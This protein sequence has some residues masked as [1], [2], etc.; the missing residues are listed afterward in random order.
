M[1]EVEGNPSRSEIECYRAFETE[2]AFSNGVLLAGAASEHHTCHM[3]R[4]KMIMNSEEQMELN[5]Q[6]RSE[7]AKDG[8]K[9][10]S[11]SLLYLG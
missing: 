9:I 1:V 7:T 11:T 4:R 6:C 8:M 3:R 2:S 10:F 5:T